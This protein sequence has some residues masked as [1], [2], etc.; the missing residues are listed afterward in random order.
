LLILSAI[1]TDYIT[2]A[3]TPEV[4]RSSRSCKEIQYYTNVHGRTGQGKQHWPL[5]KTAHFAWTWP[6]IN[7]SIMGDKV[8]DRP[9][10]VNTLTVNKAVNNRQ[11]SFW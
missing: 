6:H 3:G 7:C 5:D 9:I 10:F 2:C 8:K 1:K 11:N 4:T